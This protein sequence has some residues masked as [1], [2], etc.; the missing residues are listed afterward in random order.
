MDKLKC[1]GWCENT[2]TV[3]H[4]GEKGYAYCSEC[5]TRRRA[6]GYERCRKMRAWELQLLREGKQLPSYEL[7]SQ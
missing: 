4:I 2:G 1:D 6:S 7:R 5:A 3:T